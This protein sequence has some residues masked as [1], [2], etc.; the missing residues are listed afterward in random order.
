MPDEHISKAMALPKDKILSEIKQG[1]TAIASDL[2]KKIP[3][4]GGSLD[5]L[6]KSMSRIITIKKDGRTRRITG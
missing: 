6:A 1:V 2:V 4:V 5:E 3:I